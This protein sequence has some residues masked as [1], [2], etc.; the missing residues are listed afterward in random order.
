MFNRR[1][2]MGSLAGIGAAAAIPEHAQAQQAEL[3]QLEVSEP[4]G[5]NMIVIVCDT[6]RWDHL[7]FNG[8]NDRIQT[9]NL[10]ALAEES[11]YFS[12][13]YADSLPSIPS[14]RV[15]H[16]GKSIINTNPKWAPLLPN[17]LT[18]AQML[19]K[20]GKFTKGLISDFV[21][22]FA[23]TDVHQGTFSF[24][25]GFN[26][27]DWIR[28]NVH[29]SYISGPRSAITDAD[30][31]MPEHFM[32]DSLRERLFQYLLD[33]KDVKTEDDYTCAK[34][35]GNAGKWLEDNKDNDGSF[36]LFV[37]M[38][39]PHEPWDAPPEYTKM[40]RKDFDGGRYL[41]DYDAN[42]DA[43][44]EEDARIL[45]D[46]YAANVTFADRCIG[47]LLDDVKRLGLLD[48]TIIVFTSDH[49]THLGEMGCVMKQAKLCNSAVTRVPMLIRHPD[50][51]FHGKR[52]D[53]IVGHVDYTPT[54]LSMLGVET[55]L[56]FDGGSMWDIA[57]GKKNK[58]RD[59]IVTNYG[60]FASVH[61]KKW[62]YFQNVANDAAGFGPQLYD[63][64]N[65]TQETTN[66]A[67]S[68]PDVAAGL[69]QILK[70]AHNV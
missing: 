57:T 12:N 68:Y 59:H 15:M 4:N 20:T 58:L 52:I 64:P 13:C 28:G 37:D 36:F 53:E 2:F 10:D 63:M 32:T 35:C 33:N 6:F 67:G 3:N 34:V 5:M 48:D 7:R 1:K 56:N 55:N 14:R 60:G 26:A 19:S 69:K 42:K 46:H 17:D 66:V 8:E 39:D 38:F 51:R 41:I 25:Q 11:V 54:F 40:Y 70:Q 23:P 61:T 29:D 22:Y 24:N 43:I 31:H 18:I 9:P 62:T 47:K 27:F 50:K 49:G 30:R 21:F 65:D 44:T 16:T 45:S